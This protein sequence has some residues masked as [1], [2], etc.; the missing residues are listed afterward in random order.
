MSFLGDAGRTVLGI[1]GKWGLRFSHQHEAGNMQTSAPGFQS[2]NKKGI[3]DEVYDILRDKIL[4]GEFA[5]GER[6]DLSQI[7]E[8]LNV[9]RTPVKDALQRLSVQ[10][11]V[12]ILPRRG[13]FVSNL[14]ADAVR[15]T[16]E[17]REAIEVKAC[18]L[19]AG[20]LTPET[21]SGLRD[22]NRRMFAPD[23]RFVDHA[24]LDS[25]FHRSIVES[26]RNQRL[27]KIY[28][29]LRAHVQIARVHFRSTNWRTHNTT[30]GGEH[31]IIIDALGEGRAD[32]AKAAMQRHIRNSMQRLIAGVLHPTEDKA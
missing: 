20:N 29:D 25:E 16:F 4:S 1:E 19:A 32:E 15:E 11:L 22:L 3:S 5:P 12:E 9:S 24:V 14:T 23:L 28:L 7:S 10:D 13:T 26:S 8:Q 31:S 30:T 6:L 18:E 21:V 2:L 27:L 17:V